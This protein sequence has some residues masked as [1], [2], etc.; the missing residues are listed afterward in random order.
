VLFICFKFVWVDFLL[1][2]SKQLSSEYYGVLIYIN[3]I[4]FYFF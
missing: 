4:I 2:F 1:L 3:L